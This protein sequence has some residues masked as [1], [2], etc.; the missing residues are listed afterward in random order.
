MPIDDEI[1][2]VQRIVSQVRGSLPAALVETA[3]QPDQSIQGH[4]RE[5][6]LVVDP[7]TLT[8]TGGSSEDAVAG[9]IHGDHLGVQPQPLPR[10]P[11]QAFEQAVEPAGL[12][13]THSGVGEV[14]EIC[15]A[16]RPSQDGRDVGSQDS[17][18]V[19]ARCHLLQRKTPQ[20]GVVRD[21][22]VFGDARAEGTLDP[23]QHGRGASSPG[24]GCQVE[25]AEQALLDHIERQ[26]VQMRLEGVLDE[27]VMGAD[28]GA[29]R[30]AVH[31]PAARA[32]DQVADGVVP[33]EEGVSTEIEGDPSHRE[34]STQSAGLRFP[35]QNQMFRISQVMR[36]AQPGGSGSDDD[37]HDCPPATWE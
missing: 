30:L 28:P 13:V 18:G 5:Q 4:G 15:G 21:H 25:Q 24:F 20:F 2:Q 33:G 6:V 26:A 8:T 12:R 32:A 22:E 34:R 10:G 3:A 1:H 23:L 14:G 35:F 16:Q 27:D 17:A 7:P 19:P 36:R 9:R 29:A 11:G 31:R 37:D